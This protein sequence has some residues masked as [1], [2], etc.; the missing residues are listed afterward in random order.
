MVVESFHVG[1]GIER[2]DGGVGVECVD[3]LLGVGVGGGVVAAEGEG[4]EA[5]G[6]EDGG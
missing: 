3:R 4:E 1:G 5:G 6:E 2:A